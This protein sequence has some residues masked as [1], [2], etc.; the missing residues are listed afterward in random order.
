MNV[1]C[2]ISSLVLWIFKKSS[3]LPLEEELSVWPNHCPPW[4]LLHPFLHE[5]YH[6]ALFLGP[7]FLFQ[8]AV[9]PVQ[10]LLSTFVCLHHAYF[11]T[12]ILFGFLMIPLIKAVQP[13]VL[14]K[15]KQ[16][17]IISD[18]FVWYKI[19][20][21]ANS[22]LEIGW[23]QLFKLFILCFNFCAFDLLLDQSMKV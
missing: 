4:I 15:E 9:F 18:C 22:C 5:T 11:L 2:Q 23:N 21:V 19:C 8:N 20:C 10:I 16:L 1:H 17:L 14:K 6:E 13:I 12:G 7:L 3:C